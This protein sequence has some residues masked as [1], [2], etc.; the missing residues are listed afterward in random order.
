MTV[1][2]VCPAGAAVI[3]RVVGPDDPA[4][5]V[6]G[7]TFETADY[8]E[9]DPQGNI[10]FPGRIHAPLV[11]SANNQGFWRQNVVDGRIELL[12]RIAAPLPGGVEGETIKSWAAF[13]SGLAMVSLT[14][15]TVDASRDV[16][17]VD[18]R[19]ETARTL[20]RDGQP[21]PD[22]KP[23]TQLNYHDFAQSD[24]KENN[25]IFSAQLIGPGVTVENDAGVW[26]HNGKG[27]R[28]VVREGDL[29]PGLSTPFYEFTAKNVDSLGRASFVGHFYGADPKSRLYNNGLYAERNGEIDELLR[30]SAQAPGLASGIEI[31]RIDYPRMNIH[32][33]LTA[34]VELSGASVN[35]D[36]DRAVYVERGNGVEL[37]LREGEPVP[38]L[39][40]LI[41]DGSEGYYGARPEALVSVRNASNEEWQLLDTGWQ[42]VASPP[43]HGDP[44]PGTATEFS[45]IWWTRANAQGQRVYAAELNNDDENPNNDAGIWAEDET[46]VLQLV[47]REGDRIETRPGLFET[48][49]FDSLHSELR[50]FNDRGEILFTSQGGV[51]LATLNPVP[52]SAS[53]VLLIVG[54]APLAFFVVRRRR[55][56]NV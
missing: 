31:K 6:P 46:G 47:V 5:G 12:A 42:Q 55:P 32:G 10:R 44:A 37:L 21:A 49:D 41:W 50:G 54:A 23:G 7:A 26:V 45:H 17:L 33:H 20:V 18:L 56:R 36:N 1:V 13:G 24:S 52:E 27:L 9:F 35:D 34:P 43:Q 29:P 25:V 4:P 48:I 30:T 14:G 16:A 51:Y 8:P 2:A 28:Q 38:G 3:R 11:T 40:N 22:M 39:P 15:P 19:A 53:I